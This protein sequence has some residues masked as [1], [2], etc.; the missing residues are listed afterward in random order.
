MIKQL[1]KR[2]ITPRMNK[3]KPH[4]IVHDI[5]QST[6]AVVGGFVFFFFFLVI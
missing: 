6:L 5:T 3:Q 1:M 2:A 4:E